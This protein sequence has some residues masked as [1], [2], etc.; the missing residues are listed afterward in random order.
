MAQLQYDTVFRILFG[1]L[2]IAVVLESALAVIFN[3]RVF[4]NRFSGKSWRTPIAIAFG[5][6]IATGL[7][8][9]I[10]GALYTAI[11]GTSVGKPEL[12]LVGTFVTALVLAGGSAGVNNILKGLGFRQIGSGDGPAPKPAKTEAWLSVTL[13]RREAVGPVQV[14]VDDGQQT[15][16]VG[17]IS[18]VKPPPEWVTDFVANKVR[19]PS[20]GGHSLALGKTY[21]VSL[22]GVDKAGNAISK[23]WTPFTPGAGAIIDVVLTL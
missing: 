8:F 20:Y 10:I 2:A 18:G 14:L 13:Q 19:F 9:D 17:M 11:Y 15:V 4:Q 1:A 21:T 12:G 5:W 3:W 16:L 22:S 23:T 6:S 7:K